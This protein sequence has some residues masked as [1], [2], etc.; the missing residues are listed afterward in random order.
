MTPTDAIRKA[1]ELK[2]NRIPPQVYSII[3]DMIVEHLSKRE[4]DSTIM[5]V[6]LTQKDIVRKIVLYW[7]PTDDYPCVT[8]NDIFNNHWLDI[9]D[10]YALDGWKVIYDKPAYN[11]SYEASFKFK[12]EK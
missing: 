8:E 5:Y 4:L 12:I 3:D 1:R 10:K 11:E 2:M 6:T 9:E 7:I